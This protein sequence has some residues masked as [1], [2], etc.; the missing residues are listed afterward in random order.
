MPKDIDD[1]IS[2]MF[3]NGDILV[4]Y[5]DKV[6]LNKHIGSSSVTFNYI[7][8][9]DETCITMPDIAVI[10]FPKGEGYSYKLVNGQGFLNEKTYKEL[11]NR[12]K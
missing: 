2:S 5:K 6:L 1:S 12:K 10:F 9:T 4:T 11:E 8:E 7:P 3:S